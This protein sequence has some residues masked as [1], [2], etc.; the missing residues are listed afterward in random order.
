MNW[1]IFVLYLA[2]VCLMTAYIH[3]V[4]RLFHWRVIAV[5]I[6]WPLVSHAAVFE[7]AFI[8]SKWTLK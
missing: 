1:I 5:I 6:L 2:G 8:L 3:E 4:G 7:A